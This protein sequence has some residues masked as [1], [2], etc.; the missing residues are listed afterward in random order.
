MTL[1]NAIKDISKTW[2]VDVREQRELVGNKKECNIKKLRKG[3]T[4]ECNNIMVKL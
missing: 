3:V 4:D 2:N 1:L